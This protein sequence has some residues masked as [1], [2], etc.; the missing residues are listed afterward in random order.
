MDP[1]EITQIKNVVTHQGAL[2]GRQ[3]EKLSQISETL[4]LEVEVNHSETLS[5]LLI[6]APENPLILGHPW[7]A[8]RKP[9]FSWSTGHLL[10]WGRDCLTK[11]LRPPPRD[12]P[13]PPASIE[14]QDFSSLPLEYFHFW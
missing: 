1:A 11:Y 5:F 6:T 7:L 13:C 2:L 9:P 3:Q 10:D 8:L 14:D 4:L 12:L